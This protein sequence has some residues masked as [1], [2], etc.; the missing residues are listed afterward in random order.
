MKIAILHSGDLMGVSPGG[1]SQYVE[2][3]IKYNK[4]NKITIFGTVEH[5]SKYEFGKKYK[6]QIEGKDFEFIPVNTNKRS[7]ISIFYFINIFR[8]FKEL[9]KYDVIYVQRMEYALPFTF[10]KLRK[11]VIMA[12]HGSGA[13][14]SIYWGKGVGY[15]YNFLEKIAVRNSKKVVV[16]LKRKEYGIG[17]YRK[18]YKNSY[19]K[20]VYGKVPIDLELF[21]VL[22]K[23]KEREKL[24]FNKN[25]NILIYFGRLDNNPKRILL[26]PRIIKKLIEKNESFKC[27]IIGNGNDKDELINLIKELGVENN[28]IIKEKMTHG[29]ELTSYINV[30]D[31]SIILSN[32]EGICMSALESLACGV[33]VIATD[34]GDVNEYINN[35]SNGIVV[36]N[37]KDD[38]KLI[39]E[40]ADNIEKILTYKCKLNKIYK[41]YDGETV[42]KDLDELFK[43][44]RG[45]S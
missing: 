25:D 28:F 30:A 9:Y 26:L 19:E 4:N 41:E 38:N 16:L 18:K 23:Y 13:Y 20:I 24:G 12:V 14:S 5:N 27:I 45:G 1:I 35:S 22:D 34:V 21:K 17:Y 6:K 33:P 36:T 40:F 32:F 8:L 10:S 39:S 37:I 15:I 7:P 2:K 11:R 42:I 29:N 3:I 44:V 31:L 43:Q